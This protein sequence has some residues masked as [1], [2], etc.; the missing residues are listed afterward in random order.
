MRKNEE[1]L[2]TSFQSAANWAT[3]PLRLSSSGTVILVDMAKA[4]YS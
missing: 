3:W 2:P 1:S 4:P